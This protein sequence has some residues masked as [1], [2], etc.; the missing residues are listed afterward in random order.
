MTKRVL[1]I[2]P[3]SNVAVTDGISRAVEGLRFSDGP[4]LECATL[5]QGPFGIE[6]QRDAD[7]VILPLVD[8]VEARP[9]VSAFVIACYSDPGIDAC[10]AATSVPVFGIQESG[11]LTALVRGDRFG[12]IAIAEASI[13]RHQRY[14]RRMGVLDRLAGERAVG[15]SVDESAR[16]G[17]T[18]NKL[19]AIGKLLRED[20]A[21][22]LVLGCAGMATHRRT[23]EQ[24]IG[25]PVIDPVQAA[26]A[27]AVGAV[28]NI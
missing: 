23:L 17:D 26:A 4:E 13:A 27:M 25:C 14:M 19:V 5:A 11:I 20:G 6:S 1:I 9:D 24:T 16:G 18:F 12:V 7:S 8:M 2:N 3:N 28:A 21:D 22:V 15:I 10:R